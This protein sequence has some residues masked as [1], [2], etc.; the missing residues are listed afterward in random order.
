MPQ[1]PEQQALIMQA[2]TRLRQRFPDAQIEPQSIPDSAPIFRCTIA[3][4]TR[5]IPF[6]PDMPVCDSLLAARRKILTYDVQHLPRLQPGFGL[7]PAEADLPSVTAPPARKL[8]ET[9]EVVRLPVQIEARAK[10]FLDSGNAQTRLL[11][12]ALSEAFGVI[13]GITSL[14]IAY[15]AL[16]DY[17]TGFQPGQVSTIERKAAPGAKPGLVV[18]ANGEKRSLT[19]TWRLSLE[20]L[21]ALGP[22]KE[23]VVQAQHVAAKLVEWY[24]EYLRQR[25]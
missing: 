1:T 24:L 14:S 21:L 4:E 6:L 11:A 25:K 17:Q 10:A 22:T 18:T 2:L 19:Q 3:G 23:P 5:W 9:H 7:L 12:Q 20:E 15:E 8:F 13:A 16:E